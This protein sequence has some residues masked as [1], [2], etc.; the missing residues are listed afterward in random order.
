MSSLNTAEA[1]TKFLRSKTATIDQIIETCLSLL[2]NSTVNQVYLPNKCTFILELLSDRLND[3]SNGPFKLWKYNSSI[4]RLLTKVW[5]LLASEASSK[6]SR[7]K[8][9]KKVK[10][11][12]IIIDILSN[13]PDQELL[14]ELMNF[15][16]LAREGTYIE[17]DENN[18]MNM[19]SSFSNCSTLLTANDSDIARWVSLV[20][21][22]YQLPRLT[23]SFSPSKK[24]YKKFITTC[25][26]NL[27]HFIV[28]YGTKGY[29]SIFRDILVK[30]LFFGELVSNFVS[31]IASVLKDDKILLESS[32]VQLLFKLAVEFVASKDSALCEELFTTII[33]I[34]RFSSL[35]E[36]LLSIL[37][38]ANKSLSSKFFLAIYESE[39]TKQKQ[40]INWNLTNYLLELDIDLAM[41]KCEEV[42]TKAPKSS[43]ESIGVSILEAYVK[44]RELPDFI[45]SIWP[46]AIKVDLIYAQSSFIN[47][48][49]KNIKI[50]SSKQ[51]GLLI[52]DISNLD[53]AIQVP[54][55]TAISKGLLSCPVSTQDTLKQTLLGSKNY[56]MTSKNTR[57]EI[58]FYLLCLY[59]R[60]VDV[61]IESLK[62]DTTLYYYY[63]ILRL[64]EL[65]KDFPD[66]NSFLKSFASLLLSNPE[67]LRVVLKRWLVVIDYYFPKPQIDSIIASLVR[68]LHEF[69]ELL[70]PVFFECRK[71]P[72]SL[73]NYCIDNVDT[74]IEL[75]TLIP[76]YCFDRTSKKKL[77][78]I[79]LEQTGKT[80]NEDKQTKIRLAIKHLLEQP[81][82]TSTIET[83]FRKALNLFRVSNSNSLQIAQDIF[84][85]IWKNHLNQ[86]SSKQNEADVV[87]TV[88]YLTKYFSS[89]KFKGIDA[90]FSA[91]EIIIMNIKKYDQI[92]SSLLVHCE[93][94][95]TYFSNAV[96]SSL[97]QQLSKMNIDVVSRLLRFLELSGDESSDDVLK[98]VKEI[99]LK[100]ENDDDDSLREVRL[101]LFTLLSSRLEHTF[102]NSVYIFSLYIALQDGFNV[103]AS[104][105]L[106]SYL[107]VL[108]SN[109]AQFLK[110]YIYVLGS[111]EEAHDE[112]C[113]GLLKLI[114]LM[115]K[116]LQKSHLE[117]SK[118][119]FTRTILSISTKIGY[120]HADV[121]G[122]ILVSL[123]NSLSET[124]WLFSQYLLE[125]VFSLTNLIVLLENGNNANNYILATQVISHV[126]LFHRYKLTSRHHIVINTF[127]VLM[128]KLS[129]N[130]SDLAL[131]DSEEAAASYSRLI[132]NL[133]EPSKLVV[134]R[135]VANEKLTTATSLIK[136]SLRKHVPMLLINYIYLN[137][138]VN[139]K[140]NVNDQLMSGIYSIFDVL[141]QSELQLVSLSLDIPGKSYYRTLYN[142]YKDHGKWK[143][144]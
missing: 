32:S 84:S 81:T 82:F 133:C 71:L 20:R 19:L 79:F 101:A 52:S 144:T 49:S 142:N 128:R 35:S 126:L 120:I 60:N 55:L 73:I 31:D 129:M 139:F 29:S 111:L 51:L 95:R 22:L 141:S 70:T 61:P 16:S 48:V 130:K 76:I 83:D 124:A 127:N 122:M 44:A 67:L 30:E 45:E 11:V 38:S 94:L 108:S 121:A 54:L 4:W 118:K 91:A 86:I 28:I 36:T 41:Q 106:D 66:M 109:Y 10:L 69:G 1:V 100:I 135:E 50:L 123:K 72:K 117:E 110:C 17:I 3:W 6:T 47:E 27:L 33:G 89:K 107:Q 87:D 59:G 140:S 21:D 34:P 99:G 8:I 46:R 116:Y 12:D 115:V 39:F 7:N 112:H 65:G 37:A 43:R 96:I 63:C 132:A 93:T 102:E 40:Q 104:L 5:V 98:I 113:D 80:I 137:L 125:M 143:D 90:E 25:S 138:R 103:D 88:K 15:V 134:S 62:S 74:A 23:V 2:D 9:F 24:Y 97:K 75:T 68:H 18:S 58:L 42:V 92:E 53:D 85:I 64:L 13:A 136:K 78:E 105:A 57:W 114:L 77:L 56:Y 26:P 119:A 131:S 14:L